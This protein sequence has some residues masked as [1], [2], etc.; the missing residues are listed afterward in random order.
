M[1]GMRRNRFYHRLRIAIL[2]SLMAIVVLAVT[3]TAIF[4]P[5]KHLFPMPDK[6]VEQNPIADQPQK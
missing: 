4:G 3:L 5:P 6:D 2:L 1:A